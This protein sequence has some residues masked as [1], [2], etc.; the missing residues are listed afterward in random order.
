M[1]TQPGAVLDEPA[2]RI[3]YRLRPLSYFVR[4]DYAGVQ[5]GAD[6]LGEVRT[7]TRTQV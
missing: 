1:V 2:S 6:A 7:T 3:A 4:D 5:M